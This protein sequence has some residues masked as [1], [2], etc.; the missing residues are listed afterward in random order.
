MILGRLFTEER[1]L[2]VIVLLIDELKLRWLFA[3]ESEFCDDW[4]RVLITSN[5]HVT[6]A[7]NVPAILLIK[8]K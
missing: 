7:P 8:Y 5:G 6:T 3:L 4:Y 2:C 1:I